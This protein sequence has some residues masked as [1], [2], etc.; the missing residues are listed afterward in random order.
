MLAIVDDGRKVS[1]FTHKK[2]QGTLATLATSGTLETLILRVVYWA[3]RR[4]KIPNEL[5]FN[6]RD[7]NKFLRLHIS[8]RTNE[9]K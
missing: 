8:P 6:R 3:A 7:A 2:L 5:V 1:Q 9:N 4:N